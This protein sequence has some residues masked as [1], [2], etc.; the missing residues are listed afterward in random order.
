VLD[1]R[2]AKSKLSVDDFN[3]EYSDFSKPPE[4][5]VTFTEQPKEPED[6]KIVVYDWIKT[7][8]YS[9]INNKR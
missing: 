8:G 1:F 6:D 2:K 3:N 5:N 4:I 7:M 9:L